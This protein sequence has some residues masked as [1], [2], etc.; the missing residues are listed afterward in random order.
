MKNKVKLGY[1]PTMTP[2]VE[3]FKSRVEELELVPMQGAAIVMNKLLSGDIDAALIGREA[4]SRELNPSIKKK[5]LQSGYTL[6][7]KD[8]VGMPKEKLNEISIK[9]YLSR[10]IAMNLLPTLEHVS[11]YPSISECENMDKD[12]PMLIDWKYF[13]DEHEMLIP[14]EK[15]GMK[16]PIYRAPVIFYREEIEEFVNSKLGK[17]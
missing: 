5:R 15:N 4:Y 2:F 7:Y 13:K 8:K 9:T 17:I 12:M 3:T 6:V 16:T 10:D 1:C 14:K 11:F